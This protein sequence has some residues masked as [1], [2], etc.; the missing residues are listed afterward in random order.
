MSSLPAIT[1]SRVD[2]LDILKAEFL[3]VV[4]VHTLKAVE[5]WWS[6]NWIKTSGCSTSAG[7]DGSKE[8]EKMLTASYFRILL[9]T[10][11]LGGGGSSTKFTLDVTVQNWNKISGLAA[12]WSIKV[13]IIVTEQW[14]G[15]VLW[16]RIKKS[17]KSLWK[18]ATGPGGGYIQLQ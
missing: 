12:F 16:R 4:T 2:G 6:N 11:S 8:A 3:D 5:H 10:R 18:L 13:N 7:T 1:S 17:A 15:P 14:D 9:W